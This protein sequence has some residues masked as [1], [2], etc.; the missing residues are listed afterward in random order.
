V[1]DL[2][3]VQT[4]SGL[5]EVQG[6]GEHGEFSRAQLTTMLDLADAGIAELM[7]HQTTAIEAGIRAGVEHA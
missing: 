3:V 5:V 4:P 1:V 2:N 7:R 6:T